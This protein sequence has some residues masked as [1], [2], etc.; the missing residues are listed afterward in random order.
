MHIQTPAC[1]RDFTVIAPTGIINVFN[2]REYR[3]AR[4]AA[5]HAVSIQGLPWVE[6]IADYDPTPLARNR[7]VYA[8]T[9]DDHR[10]DA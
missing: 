6:V 10:L 2:A 1:R 5:D 7:T 4:N 9:R 3:G 8:A